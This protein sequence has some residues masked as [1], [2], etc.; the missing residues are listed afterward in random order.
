MPSSGIINWREDTTMIHD[1][2]IS[3]DMDAIQKLSRLLID[4][5]FVSLQFCLVDTE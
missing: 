1:P 4:V 3:D 2:Q 5:F